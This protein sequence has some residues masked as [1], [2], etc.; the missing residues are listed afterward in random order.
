MAFRSGIKLLK[1]SYQAAFLSRE[2]RKIQTLGTAPGCTL[3]IA[4]QRTSPFRKHSR[5]S[6]SE[7]S[8]ERDVTP[9]I[10]CNH[11]AASILLFA[12]NTPRKKRKKT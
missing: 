12:A 10:S 1:V 11:I 5:N 3:L 8:L 6:S 4:L 7:G 2:K 9:T